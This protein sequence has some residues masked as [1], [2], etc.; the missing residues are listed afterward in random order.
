MTFKE[1]F[2]QIKDDLFNMS[3]QL[4]DNPELGDEEYESMK[5][6]VN[7]LR[8]HQFDVE[9]G[10][11]DRPTSFRAEFKGEKNGPTVAFLAEYDAL[12]GIGHGCGHNLIA[13][14]AVGAGVVLTIINPNKMT[15]T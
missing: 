3:Q 8:S 5:L 15:N 13:T 10:L 7:Y 1:E 6:L 14:I 11:V 9:T 4:Y 12:P 2:N